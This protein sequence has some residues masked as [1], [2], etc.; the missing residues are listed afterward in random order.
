MSS[1][2]SLPHDTAP[3]QI[4]MLT[5]EDL[6]KRWQVSIPTIKRREKDNANGYPK[7]IRIGPRMVRYRESDILV[8]ENQRQIA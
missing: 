6:A 3:T 1:P 7:P 5:R 2:L 8:Y 4:V